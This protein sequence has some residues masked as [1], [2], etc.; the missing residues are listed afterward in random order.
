[1]ANIQKRPDGRWRARY[2]DDAGQEH[3][4][5]F[6]RK[7]EAQRWI[8]EVTTSIVTGQYVDPRAGKTSF[9]DYAEQWRAGQV[10]RPSSQAHIETM[11]RRGMEPII[12]P[13]TPS[14]DWDFERYAFVE[15]SR[16]LAEEDFPT[17]VVLCGNDRVAFGVLAAL[18][19][20]GRKVGI[21]PDCDLRVAGHDNQPLSEYIWPPLT[22]VQQNTAE[23]GRRA[24]DMLL[25]RIDT[26]HGTREQRPRGEHVLVDGDLI[27]RSSA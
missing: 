4:K 8:D 1:M 24:L 10:H 14:N 13:L 18:H 3:A 15:A 21:K 23:M 27:L 26:A 9:R 7:V 20:A 12:I 22:T 6:A 5:H 17:R 16:I 19:Q 25:A 11:R 2:R